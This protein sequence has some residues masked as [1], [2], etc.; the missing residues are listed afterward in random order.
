[1][2]GDVYELRDDPRKQGREQQGARYAVILQSD[3]LMISTVVAAPTSTSAR[4]ASYRPEVEIMGRRTKVLVE[5]MQ[6]ADPQIR[7]GRKVGR[8][9]PDELVDVDRAAK[10]VLGLF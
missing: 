10:L 9:S 2:R 6:S 1:M 4:N 8:I 7:L 5:G 3:T